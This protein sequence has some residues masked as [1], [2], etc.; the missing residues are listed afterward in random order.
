MLAFLILKTV[1]IF[2]MPTNKQH[3]QQNSHP[4]IFVGWY[5]GHIRNMW[6][7]DNDI[8]ESSDGCL[9]TSSIY[10]ICISFLNMD[11]FGSG[12]NTM[13]DKNDWKSQ[14]RTGNDKTSSY[15]GSDERNAPGTRRTLLNCYENKPTDV[16]K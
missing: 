11:I 16:H 4:W 6:N 13:I 14:E 12:T 7:A 1:N 15:G 5:D 3:S 9:T 10:S 8:L 2:S